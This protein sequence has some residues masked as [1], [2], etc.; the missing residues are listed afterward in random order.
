M[1][2]TGVNSMSTSAAE[3]DFL[4]RKSAGVSVT[5]SDLDKLTESTVAS[6]EQVSNKK[7]HQSVDTLWA[8]PA[9][10][11]HVARGQ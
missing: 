9:H 11:Q 6:R 10:L 4:Q 3:E 7:P 2:D 5:E 8:H 1:R